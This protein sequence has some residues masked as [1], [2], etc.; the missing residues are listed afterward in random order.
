MDFGLFQS[1]RPLGGDA[2]DGRRAPGQRDASPMQDGGQPPGL[3]LL[4][5]V[6]Q[7]MDYNDRLAVHSR[8]HR[9][10][11]LRKASTST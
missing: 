4:E 10:G 8:M 6:S 3:P 1:P 7:A 11:P 9:A 5:I 2:A